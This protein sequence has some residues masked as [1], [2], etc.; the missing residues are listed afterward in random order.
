MPGKKRPGPKQGRGGEGA[1]AQKLDEIRLAAYDT[2][3]ESAD[4]GEAARVEERGGDGDVEDGC[5][6]DVEESVDVA[7]GGK[8]M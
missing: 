2:S 1:K 8:Y 3:T 7:G 5:D 6:G 4:D